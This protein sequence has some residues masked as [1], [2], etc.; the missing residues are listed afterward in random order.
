MN[1]AESNTVIVARG[2]IGIAASILITAGATFGVAAELQRGFAPAFQG[3]EER[4]PAPPPAA[5][6][7]Q[8]PEII[9]PTASAGVPFPSALKG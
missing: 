1:V 5:M 3:L 6:P 4:R 2:V 8:A 7:A 9:R